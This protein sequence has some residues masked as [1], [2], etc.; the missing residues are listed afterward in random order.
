MNLVSIVGAEGLLVVKLIL[1]TSGFSTG[2]ANG[3]C[4]YTSAV[5]SAF[6]GFASI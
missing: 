5:F 6:V 2:F 3:H 4:K 1:Q